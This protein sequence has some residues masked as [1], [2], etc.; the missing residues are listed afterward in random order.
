MERDESTKQPSPDAVTAARAACLAAIERAAEA[1]LRVTR[2]ALYSPDGRGQVCLI[3]AVLGAPP[4]VTCTLGRDYCDEAARLLG[5]T[6]MQA[7]AVESAFEG[8]GGAHGDQLRESCPEYYALD[9]ELR[10]TCV[11]RFDEASDDTKDRG[12]PDVGAVET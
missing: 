1:G 10:A 12:A 7:I 11:R 3:G 9:A 6:R 5:I 4:L 8:F 2:G